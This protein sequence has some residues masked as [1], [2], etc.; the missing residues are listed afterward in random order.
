M[1]NSLLHILRKLGMH[2]VHTCAEFSTQLFGEVSV[3][4]LKSTFG[5]CSCSM[6]NTKRHTSPFGPNIPY[7]PR[8]T[9]HKCPSALTSRQG[10]DRI[11]A[12]MHQRVKTK[13]KI[14][15]LRMGHEC[16]WCLLH[17][18]KTC[19]TCQHYVEATVYLATSNGLTSCCSK[20][21]AGSTSPI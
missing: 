2:D 15:S 20:S 1:N 13:G 11:M 14:V 3:D 17:M 12:Y 19:L 21:S 5:D 18:A 6:T 10:R 8:A 16:V 9:T 4:F 7:C